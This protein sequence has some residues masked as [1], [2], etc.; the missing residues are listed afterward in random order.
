MNKLYIAMQIGC[1]ECGE[2]S[3]VLGVFTDRGTAEQLVKDAWQWHDI[4]DNWEGERKYYVYE[5]ELDVAYPY[6]DEK[7]PFHP[8]PDAVEKH[9]CSYCDCEYY[10]LE[11]GTI[12]PCCCAD[13]ETIEQEED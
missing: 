5:A 12:T 3:K 2:P 8:Y 4:L 9:Y 7:E 11:D 13:D 1:L 6:E 10:K